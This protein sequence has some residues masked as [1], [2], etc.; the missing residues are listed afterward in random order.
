VGRARRDWLADDAVG[1]EPVSK[2]QFSNNR[3][4]YRGKLQIEPENY[5]EI[6]N[7]PSI[8]ARF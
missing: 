5:D 1:F 7:K 4:K 3:E 6:I 8:H 2:S